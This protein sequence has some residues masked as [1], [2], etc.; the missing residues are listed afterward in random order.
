MKDK[1]RASLIVGGARLAARFLEVMVQTWA[2]D[3]LSGLADSDAFPLLMRTLPK[4]PHHF[5][6]I[7]SLPRISPPTPWEGFAAAFGLWSP[8][9]FVHSLHEFLIYLATYFSSDCTFIYS[10][11]WISYLFTN[12]F[13]LEWLYLCILFWF[14]QLHDEHFHSWILSNLSIETKLITDSFYKK[15][16]AAKFNTDLIIYDFWDLKRTSVIF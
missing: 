11:W 5:L 8:S 15:Q 12:F 14:L 10:F 6:W 1:E 13:F 3:I 2:I 16:I 4:P 9:S 7:L